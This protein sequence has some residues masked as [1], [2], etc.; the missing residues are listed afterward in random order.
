MD[1]A[2]GMCLAGG[3]SSVGGSDVRMDLG[4][5]DRT[6]GSKYPGSFGR[7]DVTLDL[8]RIWTLKLFGL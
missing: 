1:W 6:E 2:R 5:L 7:S 8:K 3:V 4:F